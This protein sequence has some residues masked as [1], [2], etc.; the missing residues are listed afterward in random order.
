M[1]SFTLKYLGFLK[2]IPLLP[3]L[4][5]NLL[6]INSVIFRPQLLDWIDEIEKEASGWNGITT[7]MHK[8]GGLQFNFCRHEIG[9]I[10]SNGVVDVLLSRNIKRQLLQEGRIN[11]HHTFSRSGWVTF[12]I[13]HQ[14]DKVYALHLLK[15]AVGE[16]VA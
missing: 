11:D 4:F 7:A 6:K 15:L 1:F 2:H 10:H 16:R 12:Y 14:Q 5:D 13:K 3:H 9:H 8:Y